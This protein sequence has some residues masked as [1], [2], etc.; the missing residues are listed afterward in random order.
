V[1]NWKEVLETAAAKP[2][3]LKFFDGST[4]MGPAGVGRGTPEA[5][6]VYEKVLAELKQR[7]ADK[8][9][10]LENERFRI[11]WDGMPVWGPLGAHSKLFEC[12]NLPQQLQLPLR[13]PQTDRSRYG[14]P[15]TDHRRGFERSSLRFR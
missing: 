2:A 12:Q 13:A 7:I 9:G 15:D 1:T 3:P 8:E 14:D 11:Y 4:L 10:A 5:V 6:S